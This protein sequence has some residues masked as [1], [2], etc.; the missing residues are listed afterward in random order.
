MWAF[1]T[2]TSARRSLLAA[3]G[4]QGMSKWDQRVTLLGRIESHTMLTDKLHIIM[5]DVCVYLHVTFLLV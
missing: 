4:Y 1:G 3:H 5:S 2:V